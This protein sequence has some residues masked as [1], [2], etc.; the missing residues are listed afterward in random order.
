MGQGGKV[1]NEYNGKR[2]GNTSYAIGEIAELYRLTITEKQANNVKTAADK[3]TQKVNAGKEF[4]DASLNDTCAETAR[5]ILSEGGVSTPNGSGPVKGGGA[6]WITTHGSFVNPY[7]W[8]FDFLREYGPGITYF[9]PRG[10]SALQSSSPRGRR[11]LVRPKWVLVPGN[12]DPLIAT[13]QTNIVQGS[14]QTKK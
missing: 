12:M 11:I 1:T 4:Y 14:L 5:D 6:D 9:G 8:N 3:F 2:P 7:K 10:I 13:S